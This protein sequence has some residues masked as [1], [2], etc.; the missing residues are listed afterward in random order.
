MRVQAKENLGK[1]RSNADC[2]L[3]TLK[4][5]GVRGLFVGLQ[6]TVWRNSVWNGVYFGF[7]HLFRSRM[8]QN[9][10]GTH[11]TLTTLVAG[12]VGGLL[13]TMVNAPFDVVKSRR[14]AVMGGQPVGTWRMLAEIR[15]TEGLAACYKGFRP[16]VSYATDVL[17]APVPAA[18]D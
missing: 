7:M 6:H 8:P 12:F 10:P 18:S 9:E 5:E 16:K 11:D 2:V 13:A 1:F 15:R 3:Q 4:S 14:Q 17:D